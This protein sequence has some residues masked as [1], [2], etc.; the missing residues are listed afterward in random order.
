MSKPAVIMALVLWTCAVRPGWTADR[1]LGIQSARVMSQSMPWIASE[2][3]IFRKYNLEF[4]LVYIGTSPL[5]TAAMLGGDA[6]LL[7][8]GGVGLVRTAV[9]GNSEL[10][11]IAGIKNYLTQSILA[12]PEIKRLEDLRGKKVGVTRVGAT[13]HYFAVQAFK[14]RNME[15]GRD[16]LMIQT[17]GAP[18]MLAA[19]LSGA[20]DA[21]TMSA[22]WDAR[23]VSQGYSYVVYGPDLKIPHVAVSF[24]TR[25]SFIA[26]NSPLVGRFMRAMAEAA[27]IL[28][29]DKEIVFKVLSKY[30]R[31]E[32][33]KVL[34][35]AYNAEIKALEPRMELRLEAVQAVLDDIAPSDARARK[36]KPQEFYDRRYLEEMEK[37]GFF[38]KLWGPG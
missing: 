25:R 5:A 20:I 33:R 9:S 11:Y 10:V 24:I 4:P 3:G 8:D 32:D 18:E 28:H 16:Y 7:I 27:K 14:R 2:I 31:I 34:D 13:T 36:F 23:A 19:L 21:G 15:A 30:L 12:K 26:K 22:P 6:Q 1:L 38:E 17:G 35:Q 29:T 37:S